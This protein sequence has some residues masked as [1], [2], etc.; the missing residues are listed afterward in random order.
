M[1]L[2]TLEQD[3]LKRQYEPITIGNRTSYPRA[4][5]CIASQKPLTQYQLF[6]LLP[7]LTDHAYN[8]LQHNLDTIC[9]LANTKDR[10]VILELNYDTIVLT[11]RNGKQVTGQLTFLVNAGVWLN[12]PEAAPILAYLTSKG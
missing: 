7:K 8:T 12:T 9:K 6:G 10:T 3:L 1:E 2:D 5:F 4:Y 11:I